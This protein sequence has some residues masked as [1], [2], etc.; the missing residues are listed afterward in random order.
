[1]LRARWRRRR[2]RRAP[3][4]AV[5]GGAPTTT[6]F[7]RSPLGTRRTSA[8]WPAERGKDGV[9]DARR[10]VDLVDRVWS[11][12]F[13]MR[14][15]ACSGTH[16]DPA[17]PPSSCRYQH[18]RSPRRR[19]RHHVERCL[20]HVCGWLGVLKRL[21]LPSIADTLMMKLALCARPVR[22]ERPLLAPL[23]PLPIARVR[24]VDAAPRH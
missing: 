14:E 21:N 11:C 17:C 15:A 19:A 8:C 22:R 13:V 23:A 18:A 3:A 24:A 6:R 5:G 7:A 16:V 20:G 4:I 12:S 2:A 10:S 9:E 1:M